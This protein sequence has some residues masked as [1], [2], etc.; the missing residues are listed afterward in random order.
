[1]AIPNKAS[2]KLRCEKCLVN[3]GN[4]GYPDSIKT[5]QTQVDAH[6]WARSVDSEMDKGPFSSRSWAAQ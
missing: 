1:M 6:Q 3:W 2:V 5:F 4:A